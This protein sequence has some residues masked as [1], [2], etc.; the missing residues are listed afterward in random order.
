M[1]N[2]Y[3]ELIAKHNL[4]L[5]IAEAKGRAYAIEEL[6]QL[7]YDKIILKESIDKNE[8]EYQESIELLIESGAKQVFSLQESLSKSNALLQAAILARDDAREL[9]IQ[10]QDKLH[11]ANQNIIPPTPPSI[12]DLNPT[13]CATCDTWDATIEEEVGYALENIISS[14]YSFDSVEKEFKLYCSKIVNNSVKSKYKIFG[15]SYDLYN[16]LVNDKP[17]NSNL[18]NFSQPEIDTWKNALENAKSSLHTNL[19]SDSTK[20]APSLALCAVNMLLLPERTCLYKLYRDKNYE[21]ETMKS[22]I[23]IL[24]LELKSKIDVYEINK[25][26]YSESL[27]SMNSNLQFK[28][29]KIINLERLTEELNEKISKYEQKYHKVIQEEVNPL[30]L[31]IEQ[32]KSLI[33]EKDSK[34]I[35]LDLKYLSERQESEKSIAKHV[36]NLT[37]QYAAKEQKLKFD[38]SEVESKF[39]ELNINFQEKI[40]QIIIKNSEI[41]T[42]KSS[43]SNQEKSFQ[44][45]L[46][47]IESTSHDVRSELELN[48]SKEIG[49][50][51]AKITELNNLY[52]NHQK[53]LLASDSAY[54]ASL[55]SIK[56]DYEGRYEKLKLKYKEELFESESKIKELSEKIMNLNSVL[57]EK[58]ILIS[59]STNNFTQE[60]DLLKSNI[61]ELKNNESKFKSELSSKYES[62]KNILENKLSEIN[63]KY[64]QLQETYSNLV[65][66][67][68]SLKK[69]CENI[70][71]ESI[72]LRSDAELNHVAELSKLRSKISELN[73][74]ISASQ[75]ELIASDEAYEVKLLEMKKEFDRRVEKIR[76]ETND[77]FHEK[78]EE[79]NHVVSEN[80]ELKSQLKLASLSTLGQEAEVQKIQ[81]E[82]A[83]KIKDIQ[84][85]YDNKI[86]SYEEALKTNNLFIN[87]LNL[88]LNNKDNEIEKCNLNSSDLAKNNSELLVQCKSLENE[89]KTHKQNI[90]DLTS[91]LKGKSLEIDSIKIA[92]EK[93]IERFS[94][95]N[96]QNQTKQTEALLLEKENSLTAQFQK[97]LEEAKVEFENDKLNAIN[98][99]KLEFETHL[100]N[101][102]QSD[103]E[104][105][106]IS[107]SNKY[108]DDLE[109]EKQKFSSEKNELVHKL[110]VEISL[111]ENLAKNMEEKNKS[112][113]EM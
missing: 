2:N 90:D 63:S 46:E 42:L 62:E 40:N 24:E 21:I 23:E 68:D 33:A 38:L 58:D 45:T 73:E 109:R 53:D 20:L 65:K 14:I 94:E 36:E 76:N 6:E 54:E 48:N 74:I 30:S 28:D 10:S 22:T 106:T 17:K 44:K 43:L 60:I 99:A 85:E 35:E 52:A 86:L 71:S 110:S 92:F 9:L 27:D 8:K 7:K 55:K 102:F 111:R 69:Y 47:E 77:E 26:K 12:S 81:N 11:Y 80:L 57:K 32:L 112:L 107:I 89:L 91:Q 100:K 37:T 39:F 113:N 59:E 29:D 51:R 61:Y 97:Q 19:S 95:S 50:L 93:E 13:D 34:L 66:E 82:T 31:E 49:K 88:Q 16:I 84:F 103:K 67:N 1:E 70:K 108:N 5:E 15:P 105:Q 41:E 78:Q 87:E 83:A 98:S 79:L 72:S 96:K 104:A 18:K 101:Q 25:S 56:E 64:N 3:E 4:E 75:K